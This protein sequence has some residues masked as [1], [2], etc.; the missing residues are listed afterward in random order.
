MTFKKEET[1]VPENI[2][3]V[4]LNKEVE[5]ERKRRMFF[6]I[7]IFDKRNDSLQNNHQISF[8]KETKKAAQ[9]TKCF[10]SI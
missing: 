7:Y 6:T 2:H 1:D 9:A 3:G 5:K 4:S 10:S 8:N